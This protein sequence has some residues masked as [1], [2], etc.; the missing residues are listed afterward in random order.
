MPCSCHM[1]ACVLFASISFFVPNILKVGY[2]V[3]SVLLN[4]VNNNE[5]AL[6]YH[7]ATSQSSPRNHEHFKRHARVHQLKLHNCGDLQKYAWE[8]KDQHKN[9][10]KGPSHNRDWETLKHFSVRSEISNLEIQ[11][12]LKKQ[13]N[14]GSSVICTV[15][16]NPHTPTAII[17]LSFVDW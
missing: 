7:R 10:G 12:C 2:L 16:F 6:G 11:K 14:K 5:L 17:Q 13:T 3:G 4:V 9:H 1:C 8:C 15:F